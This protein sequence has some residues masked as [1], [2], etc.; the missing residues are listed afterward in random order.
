V[1]RAV[2]P[3]P[4]QRATPSASPRDRSLVQSVERA[5]QILDKLAAVK[6]PVSAAD[7]ARASDLD[8]TVVHRLL[9]TM[10]ARKLVDR[11]G[12]GYVLGSKAL[13]YGTAYLDRL[14]IRR[15]ALPYMSDVQANLLTGHPW[16][17]GLAVPTE[18]YA[19][20]VER[21]SS[22]T[23]PLDTVVDIGSQFSFDT[24]SLGRSMLAYWPRTRVA[25]YC[26]GQC[27]P[28][29]EARLGEIRAAGGIEFSV[30]ETRP[31]IAALAA[32]I[33]K[34]EVEP[35]GSINVF[36]LALQHELR[37]DSHIALTLRRIADRIGTAL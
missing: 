23:A 6:S 17:V 1:E 14:A 22:P 18:Q 37:R 25:A 28:E 26:G 11:R 15:I 27:S 2:K 21:L 33:L 20:L 32:V 8:R 10:E 13:V 24:S 36:G 34:G 29:L 3:E 9:K 5:V 30:S 31:G 7:L 12:A 35:V 4:A 16:G 19:V